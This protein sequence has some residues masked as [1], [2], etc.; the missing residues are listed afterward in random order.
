[1]PFDELIPDGLGAIRRWLDPVLL[2]YRTHRRSRYR[3]DP[4]FAE[5]AENSGVSP[6]GSLGY[7]ENK[8]LEVPLCWRSS[9]FP[10]G[11]LFPAHSDGAISGMCYIEQW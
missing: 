5:L 2:E 1:M 9:C 3:H 10:F 11:S 6:A 8:F 7:F 4:E